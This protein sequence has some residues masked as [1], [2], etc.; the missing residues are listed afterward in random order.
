MTNTPFSAVVALGI[1]ILAGLVVNNGIV[2]ID[3][4]NSQRRDGHNLRDAIVSGSTNRVR[5]ILMTAIVTILGAFP[6]AVG[7]GKGDE[8][9]S[10]LAVVTFGGIFLSTLLTIIVIPILYFEMEKWMARRNGGA[11][12]PK[13]AA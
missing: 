8:L 5:P 6:L 1:V 7:I 9:A 10:P 2:L 13:E 12:E 11:N 3:L 4:I